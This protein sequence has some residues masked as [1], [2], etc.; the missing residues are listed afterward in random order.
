VQH[1]VAGLH[2]ARRHRHR[3]GGAAAPA[4]QQARQPAPA[5]RVRPHASPLPAVDGASGYGRMG[6]WRGGSEVE[7]RGGG[8]QRAEERYHLAEAASPRLLDGWSGSRSVGVTWQMGPAGK[9]SGRRRLTKHR[10]MIFFLLANG[11]PTCQINLSFEDHPFFKLLLSL[12]F[13]VTLNHSFYFFN[14]FY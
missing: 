12:I 14:S 6:E 13:L 5:S 10:P 3:R 2:G 1:G 8:G 4:A 9:C 7:G 11:G